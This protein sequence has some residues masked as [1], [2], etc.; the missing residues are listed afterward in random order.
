MYTSNGNLTLVYSSKVKLKKYLNITYNDKV[1]IEKQIDESD[2]IF[3]LKSDNLKDRFLY[4]CVEDIEP[5][6]EDQEF[7][8]I[9]YE[10][11]ITEFVEISKNDI[12]HLNY[13]NLNKVDEVQTFLYYYILGDTT[14]SNS[15]NFK[16]DPLA[17]KTKYINIESGLYHTTRKLES[18]E[19]EKMFHF[20]DN[21]LPVEYDINSDEYKKIYFK[22]SDT[23]Y[24][25]RY[26][27]FKIEISKLEEYFS[28]K[29]IIITIGD[30]VDE[31]DFNNLDY[32]QPKI[33]TKDIKPYFPTYFKLKLNPNERDILNSPYPQN[34]IYVKGDLLDY[35]EN[36]IIIINKII[37]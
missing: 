31:I 22:D 11:G 5:G 19:F 2:E 20:G 36:G 17:N 27:F 33:I 6:N 32:Y 18:D 16:I 26:I 9:V 13:V 29:N 30:E 28:P 8:I 35:D 3:Y 10:K 1:V 34:S 4:I 21:S 12:I 23:S 15:I 7:S 25:Y 24:P 37:L 14:K